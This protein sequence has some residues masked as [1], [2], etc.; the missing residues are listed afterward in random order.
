[1]NARGFTD[2]GLTSTSTFWKVSIPLVIASIIVPVAFSGLLIRKT[3]QIAVNMKAHLNSFN[4]IFYTTLQVIVLHVFLGLCFP[5]MIACGVLMC[6]ITW[7]AERVTWMFCGLFN[8]NDS[9]PS[10]PG[11]IILAQKMIR[12]F[13]DQWT[14]EDEEQNGRQSFPDDNEGVSNQSIEMA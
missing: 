8:D 14:L 2:G 3:M 7:M 10:T 1:M 9:H 6:Y 13:K 11:C 4:R 5:C 12:F